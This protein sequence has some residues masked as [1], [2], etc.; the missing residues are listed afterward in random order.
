[1]NP[2]HLT[3]L[4]DA[5][6]LGAARSVV[7]D[8]TGVLNTNYFLTT[9]R[10]LFFIKSVREKMKGNIAYIAAVETFMKERGIAAVCMQKTTVGE[11]FIELEGHVYTVYPFI[12]SD[13]SHV[14]TDS[15]IAA[16]GTLLAKIHRAG[17]HDVP[18][19]FKQKQITQKQKEPIIAKLEKYKAL[20][21]AKPSCDI[22]DERFLKY[23]T[24]KLNLMSRIA[25]SL[26][27]ENDTLVHGDFHE[28]NLLID[29][30][31]RQIVGVCDW[32]KAEF[33]PR[34]YEVA[35][36]VLIIAFSGEYVLE[37]AL[38]TAAIFLK[39]YQTTYPL[40]KAE[41]RAGLQSRARS[42][43]LSQWIEDQYYN[44]QDSRPV[45]FLSREVR[46]L[47]DFFGGE[48]LEKL[49]NMI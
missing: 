19:F 47:E 36:S 48:L 15:D 25:D 14:Y 16:M 35:R 34:S 1:M 5:F 6:N 3:Q 49:E 22:L 2:L 40:T 42:A 29:V 41:W 9:D 46:Q 33:M 27:F 18:D 7:A 11:H 17:S 28:R 21:L 30:A 39:A 10:G 24:V 45:R 38:Q 20:I 37:Q 26:P 32:E 13:Q 44:H 8:T 12:D 31:S 4:L 43:V 23:I